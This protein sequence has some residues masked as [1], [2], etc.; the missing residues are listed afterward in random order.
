MARVMPKIGGLIARMLI[1]IVAM[2]LIL[3]LIVRIGKTVYDIA[4]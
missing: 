1:V 4:H 2:Y 3:F